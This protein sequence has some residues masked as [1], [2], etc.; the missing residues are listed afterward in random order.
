MNVLVAKDLTLVDTA[1]LLDTGG[2]IYDIANAIGLEKSLH[3][4]SSVKMIFLV[5]ES[6]IDEGRGLQLR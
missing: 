6:T 1:G 4:T 3:N 5:K 2:P